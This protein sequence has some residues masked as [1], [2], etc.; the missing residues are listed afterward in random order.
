[1]LVG[2]CVNRMT[3]RHRERP[4]NGCSIIILGAEIGRGGN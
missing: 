2:F 3:S 4:E 1:M